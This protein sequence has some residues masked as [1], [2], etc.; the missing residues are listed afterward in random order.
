MLSSQQPNEQLSRYFQRFLNVWNTG[1]SKLW[2]DHPERR[3]F[4]IDEPSQ[5]DRVRIIVDDWSGLEKS[6]KRDH[7][8]EKLPDLRANLGEGPYLTIY[9]F[10]EDEE[11]Y[12]VFARRFGFTDCYVTSYIFSKE[13]RGVIVIRT[14]YPDDQLDD[15]SFILPIEGQDTELFEHLLEELSKAA[16]FN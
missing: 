13:G 6:F 11:M 10:Y 5:V 1:G 2:P 15:E 16:P 12:K 7:S 3:D 9:V 4:E 14:M 8:P